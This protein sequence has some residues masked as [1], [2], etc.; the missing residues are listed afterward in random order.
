MS[1]TPLLKVNPNTSSTTGERTLHITTNK[2]IHPPLFLLNLTEN[3]DRIRLIGNTDISSCDARSLCPVRVHI[4]TL[5]WS[6]SPG[7][8]P[9]SKHSALALHSAQGNTDP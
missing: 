4:Q 8:H 6:G 7:L 2:L 3:R 1:Y 5:V 9:Y